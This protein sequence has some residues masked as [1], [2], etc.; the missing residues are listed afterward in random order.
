MKLTR[1]VHG[2]R[3]LL[4]IPVLLNMHG[5]SSKPAVTEKPRIAVTTSWLE[6]AV[7]DIAGQDFTV[8]RLLPPGDCPGHFDVSPG[9]IRNLSRCPL[10]LRFDFQEGLD[11]KLSGLTSRGL[12]IVEIQNADGLCVPET[13]LNACRQVAG[14]LQKRYPV[15]AENFISRLAVSEG[16]L[17]QLSTTVQKKISEVRL[18]GT[19]VVASERQQTFCRWLGLDVVCTFPRADDMTPSSLEKL[20]AVA[21][22]SGARLIVAN[23]QEGRQAADAI[24]QR[25]DARVV[26]FS[27]FP[28]ME[29]GQQRYDDL[30]LSNV[31]CLVKGAR[32]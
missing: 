15:S 32:P 5:C 24:A 21:E 14:V 20:I 27:N 23:L 26:V 31:G 6:C 29:H 4:F 9:T 7:R 12:K 25:L 1:L 28:S 17:S 16:R 22:T 8:L 13:Y 11:T 30:V 2:K 3:I 19:R 18:Q 10:L